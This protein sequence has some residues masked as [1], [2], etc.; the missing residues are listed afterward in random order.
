MGAQLIKSVASKTNDVAGDGVIVQLSYMGLFDSVEIVGSTPGGVRN[1]GW[2]IDN[3]R[4]DVAPVPVPA[5]GLLL[6]SALGGFA[7][8]RRRKRSS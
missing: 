4:S 6:M 8:M 1:I 3:I 5:A 7:A 2:G